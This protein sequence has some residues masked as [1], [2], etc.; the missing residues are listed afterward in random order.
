MKLF[1][2]TLIRPSAFTIKRTTLLFALFP[3]R[4]FAQDFGWMDTQ[5]ELF[6]QNRHL[7]DSMENS[8]QGVVHQAWDEMAAQ[9]FSEMGE[10]PVG[11]SSL[12][13]NS[14]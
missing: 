7:A 6:Q 11:L 14:L 1:S 13:L 8:P 3:V 10:L 5:R 12:F 4:S 2:R 9:D